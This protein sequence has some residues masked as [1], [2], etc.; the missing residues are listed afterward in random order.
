MIVPVF[1]TIFVAFA[2]SRVFLRFRSGDMS[3]GEFLFWL[4]IWGA[5]EAVVWIPKFLDEIAH[6][7]G[8]GRG[9]DA[10]VYGPVVL[11]FY[12]VYRIYVK[13]EFIEHE[14]TSLVRQIALKQKSPR[15]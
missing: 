4:G 7:I 11:L 8:I 14:I 15:E 12:L 5:I 10:V 9:I 1:V 13:A 3:L 6:Q 2:V